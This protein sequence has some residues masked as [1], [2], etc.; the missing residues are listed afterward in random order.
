MVSLKDKISGTLS[1][2][3]GKLKS[4]V[5]KPYDAIVKVKD[6]ASSVLS[7]IKGKL[8]ALAGGVTIGVAVKESLGGAMQLQQDQTT[9]RHFMGVGNSGKDKTTLDKMASDYSSW[10]T[11]NANMT[12]FTNAEVM[13][14]GAKALTATGGNV[15]KAKEM[16]ARA[17]DMAGLMGKPLEQADD[18]LLDVNIGQYAR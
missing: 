1:K 5:K 17:E 7:S 13:A 12:P 8:T 9:I 11:N 3:V 6:K 18:A 4:F 16:L 2:L 15:E 10:L 14:G